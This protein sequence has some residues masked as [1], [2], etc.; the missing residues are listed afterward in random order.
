MFDVVMSTSDPVLVKGVI[1]LVIMALTHGVN[2]C[3]GRRSAPFAES[4]YV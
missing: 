3:L 4:Y 1:P 2:P